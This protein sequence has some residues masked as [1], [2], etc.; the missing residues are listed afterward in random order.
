[1]TKDGTVREPARNSKPVAGVPRRDF[2][3]A[4]AFVAG[5]GVWVATGARSYGVED[6]SPNDKINIACIGVGGKGDS[7]SDHCALHGNVVAIC[8]VDEKTLDRKAEKTTK[9]H[10]GEEVTPFAKAKKYTDFRKM[11]EDMG[12]EIDAV[13][14]STPDHTHAVAT[15]QAI[16]MGKHVYTQKPLAHDV[17]EVRQLRLAAAEHKI[18][19]QMGNQ[20]TRNNRF[21]EGV[22]T[23]RAGVIGAVKEVHVWTNRPIW[24]QAP[25]VMARLKPEPVPAT[26]HWNEWLGTAPEREYNG[27]YAPFNWR[28][29]WD[30]GTGALGDM[31][32][33]TVNM[34]FMALKLEYPISV[35]GKAGDLNPET[36]PSWARVAFEFPSRG[37]LPPVT[38]HW[39]EGRDENGLVHPPKEL[40]EKVMEEYN[41]LHKGKGGKPIELSN[42]GSI[43]VGEKGMI[44]S[45][46]D[47]GGSWDLLPVEDFKDHK[48]VEAVLP[49]NKDDG[50]EGNKIEWLEAARG[51]KPSIGNFSYAGLLAETILL[52]NIAIK[53][54][55]KKLEWDGPSLRFTNAPEADGLLRRQYRAPWSL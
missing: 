27:K 21:R 20:G 14:I 28:G 42:S 11:F 38:L 12:K 52:G 41:K 7:D 18:S 19:S 5:A 6:Q 8:D 25:K 4:S 45:P 49:R 35:E 30:F 55:G 24:P 36:Y 13:T 46:D 51:G 53:T 50:D 40:T 31:G 33:H 9:N 44:Y 10:K 54:Q 32:C 43:M 22:D 16:K 48:P 34:P 1:M 47:Y 3:K 37:E 29:W 39:Y 2:L 23:V 15:M 26:M 17:Y